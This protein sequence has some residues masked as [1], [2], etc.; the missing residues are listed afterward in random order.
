M[1]ENADRSRQYRTFSGDMDNLGHELLPRA[2]VAPGATGNDFV[3]ILTVLAD[4][5]ERFDAMVLSQRRMLERL[6]LPNDQF[7]RQAQ[8]ISVEAAQVVACAR[9]AID[10]LGRLAEPVGSIP[11][12]PGHRNR[13]R[14]LPRQRRPE[15]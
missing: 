10:Q 3:R 1:T 4:E 11:L 7:D 8:R 15:D 14:G 2:S 13:P 5:V 12:Q 6:D 9:Q